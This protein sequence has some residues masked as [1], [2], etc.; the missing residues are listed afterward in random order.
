[1][2][3]RGFGMVLVMVGVSVNGEANGGEMLALTMLPVWCAQNLSS[4]EKA[5]DAQFFIYPGVERGVYS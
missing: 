2:A 4:A 3:S 1:M 5:V